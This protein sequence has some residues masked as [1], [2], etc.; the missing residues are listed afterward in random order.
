MQSAKYKRFYKLWNENKENLYMKKEYSHRIDYKQAKKW[1]DS[2]GDMESRI[3]ANNIIKYTTFISFALFIEK[4]KDICIAY[5]NFYSNKKFKNDVFIMIV[6]FKLSKSNLWVSLLAFKFLK[7]IVVDIYENI[8]S[9]YTDFLD[10]K[11]KLYNKKV[12]CIVCDDCSYTGN[13][14]Y[15]I[16]RIDNTEL[17]YPNIESEPSNYERGWLD[18]NTRTLRDSKKLIDSKSID[19]FSVDLIIPYMTNNA[20]EKIKNIHYVKV[21]KLIDRVPL[22]SDIININSIP[23]YI[24]SEFKK[25]FQY[26]N[27]ITCTYFDHKVA[28]AVSTFNKIYNLAPIFNYKIT[29]K[30][31]GF[32]ENCQDVKT[33]PDDID[34]YDYYLDTG[35]ESTLENCPKTFYKGIKYTYNKKIVDTNLTISSIIEGDQ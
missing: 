34:I 2:Q 32:I 33:L 23:N 35:K 8:T 19:V 27:Q 17:K 9:V 16:I 26:H 11:S 28:D 14:L 20:I 1:A 29:N 30:R 5:K 31:I 15:S 18:W 6:P 10:K 24:L 4:I 7:D 12:R 21:S 3:F 25:T 22:F 13:Q